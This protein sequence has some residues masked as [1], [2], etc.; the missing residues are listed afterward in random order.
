MPTWKNKRV[1]IDSRNL[2]TLYSVM[3]MVMMAGR[4]SVQFLFLESD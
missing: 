1:K 3:A 4:M 2:E